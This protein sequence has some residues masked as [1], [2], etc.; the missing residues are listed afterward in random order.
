MIFVAGL[1]NFDENA[2]FA[3][4]PRL[5]LDNGDLSQYQKHK[6]TL[7]LEELDLL[8]KDIEVRETIATKQM[9]LE[10]A[11]YKREAEVQEFR[12]RVESERNELDKQ[13]MALEKD[14]HEMERRKQDM[15]IAERTQ[16]LDTMRQQQQVLFQLLSKKLGTDTD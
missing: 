3:K 1:P 11:K 14:K 2:H 10:E 12:L 6:L 7:K 15:E 13:R 16:H 9:Q 8:R 5:A 4:I